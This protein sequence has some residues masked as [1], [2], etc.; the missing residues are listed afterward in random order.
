MNDSIKLFQGKDALVHSAFIDWCDKHPKG[1]V[2]NLVKPGSAK[3]HRAVCRHLRFVSNS[4]AKMT[5]V[6]KYCSADRKE[7]LKAL[8]ELGV[9]INDCGTCI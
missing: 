2:A 7:L 5:K 4:N 3:L 9:Q 6:A 8:D 1:W